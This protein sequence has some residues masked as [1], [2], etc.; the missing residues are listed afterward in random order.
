MRSVLAVSLLLVAGLLRALPG[1]GEAF[2]FR[3]VNT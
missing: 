2:W 3:D 1:T